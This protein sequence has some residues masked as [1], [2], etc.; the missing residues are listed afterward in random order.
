MDII[1]RLDKTISEDPDLLND[2]FGIPLPEVEIKFMDDTGCTMM[3]ILDGDMQELMGNDTSFAT[4]PLNHLM[5]YDSF[6][7]ANG[8]VTYSKIIAVQVNMKGI[9][10]DNQEVL[11]LNDWTSLPCAVLDDDGEGDLNLLRLNGPWLR[12][13]FY[14]GS[15][16][17]FPIS[18]YASTAKTGLM[19]KDLIPVIREADR[20]PPT[21]PRPPSGVNW[22]TDPDS[23]K[24][25]PQ[26]N[27]N[28]AGILPPQAGA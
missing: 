3:T 8:S 12:Q 7:N 22:V 20:Q 19:S 6:I 5:G 13:M 14:V 15:A 9:D 1:L 26:S 4:A 10:K 17:E 28:I 25:V 18:L 24:W 16:P 2:C 11:M 21:F 27:T 23:G